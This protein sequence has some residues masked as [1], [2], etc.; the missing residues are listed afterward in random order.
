MT[1]VAWLYFCLAQTVLFLRP[2]PP[3][4]KM[5]LGVVPGQINRSDHEADRLPRSAEVTV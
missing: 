2:T 1:L 3:P 5:V 4:T